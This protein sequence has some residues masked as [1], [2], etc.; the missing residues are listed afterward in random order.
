MVK[1]KKQRNCVISQR[2]RKSWGN[3]NVY[4]R[5]LRL[6]GCYW[7]YECVGLGGDSVFP[8]IIGITSQEERVKVLQPIVNAGSA[9][10]RAGNMGRVASIR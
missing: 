9:D 7:I 3:L 1:I 5:K 2:R 10:C 8:F 6:R 4:C